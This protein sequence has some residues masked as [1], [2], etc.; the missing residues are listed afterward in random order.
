MAALYAGEVLRHQNILDEAARFYRR[1]L[2]Y[3]PDNPHLQRA[4][5]LLGPLRPTAPQPHV[6]FASDVVCDGAPPDMETE[7]KALHQRAFGS[8]LQKVVGPMLTASGKTFEDDALL[9][10]LRGKR[11]AGFPLKVPELETAQ[12]HQLIGFAAAFKKAIKSHVKKIVGEYRLPYPPRVRVALVAG[13]A[14]TEEDLTEI[15]LVGPLVTQ[16]LTALSRD[17]EIFATDASTLG[18]LFDAAPS[19][20]TSTMASVKL[21]M[22]IAPESTSRS[23]PV[24]LVT[25]VS[26][27]TRPDAAAGGRPLAARIAPWEMAG[28]EHVEEANAELE[29]RL[30]MIFEKVAPKPEPTDEKGGIW[31]RFS[32]RSSKPRPLEPVRLRTRIFEPVLRGSK[33]YLSQSDIRQWLKLLAAVGRSY[34]DAL[35][36]EGETFRKA[37]QVLW[38]G[39]KVEATAQDVMRLSV[40]QLFAVSEACRLLGGGF[41]PNRGFE[42]CTFSRLTG[43]AADRLRR[44]LTHAGAE[45]KGV[46]GRVAKVFDAAID[47]PD[48][49]VEPQSFFEFFAILSLIGVMDG[50]RGFEIDHL[51]ELHKPGTSRYEEAVAEINDRVD[52]Y[53][54]M[55]KQGLGRY[56]R[57][58][59]IFLVKSPVAVGA[60]QSVFVAHELPLYTH[61]TTVG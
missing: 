37:S 4:L 41:Q 36:K 27:A 45:E 6:L 7:L 32:G 51:G 50:T 42:D 43:L 40:E 3:E 16:G 38:A 2:R 28:M 35:Y 14:P 12:R 26:R 17:K 49:S 33:L 59:R 1:G 8:A 60:S 25:P 24:L 13:E 22:V 21:G 10:E 52:R 9:F 23:N 44:L 29:G 15:R 56:A 46:A 19:E 53:T 5:K 31:D 47:S 54:A 55:L 57:I 58:H 34:T 48:D 61:V 18:E 11:L 39:A 30:Q 20:L